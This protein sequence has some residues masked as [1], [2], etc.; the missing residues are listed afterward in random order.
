MCGGLRSKGLS[1]K[2]SVDR[3][4]RIRK[5]RPGRKRR[6]HHGLLAGPA[7]DPPGAVTGRRS[8]ISVLR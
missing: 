2:S 3:V 1:L 5:G 7:P 6:I 8:R 4:Q